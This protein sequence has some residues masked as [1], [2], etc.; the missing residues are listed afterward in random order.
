MGASWAKAPDFAD[1]PARRAAVQAQTALDK[2]RYLEDG[3]TPLHC[4]GCHSRVL[5]RKYSAHQTS[6]EWTEPPA[7]RCPVFAGLAESGAAPGRP[8]TCPSLEKTIKWAVDEG[9]L[10][11]PE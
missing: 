9:V 3:M 10:P 2:Q 6:V 1:Q 11:I 7:T 5:V 8:D 4:Q